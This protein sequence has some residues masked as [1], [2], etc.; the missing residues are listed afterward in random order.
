[1]TI[2]P[3]FRNLR[4]A[5]Q[6]EID[7]LAFDSDGR[8]VLAQRLKQR[9][10]ELSFLIS[11]LE[12]SPEMVAVVL[13][14]AFTY[15]LPGAMEH[16]LRHEADDLPE[17][18][19]VADTVVIAPWAEELVVQILQQPQGAWFMT[20]AAAL[21]YLYGR[22]QRQSGAAHDT[23]QDDAHDGNEDGSHNDTDASDNSDDTENHSGRRNNPSDDPNDEDDSDD[24][25]S[26]E[27][28]G[29]DW[30]AEQGFDRKD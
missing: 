26:L 9:R 25:R 20:L 13:N 29:A 28:S 18:D 21:E 24:V 17:W 2:S 16:V 5:Y 30:M 12:L 7:D 1:M 19:S 10:K 4:T 27:D 22:P 15:K 23:H 8:N 11:M 6:A 3:F 14:K